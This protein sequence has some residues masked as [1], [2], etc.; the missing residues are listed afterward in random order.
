MAD[1]RCWILQK[2]NKTAIHYTLT[3]IHHPLRCKN[4]RSSHK[5]KINFFVDVV[6]CCWA[7]YV[8]L[9]TKTIQSPE[10]SG[11]TRTT[12]QRYSQKTRILSTSLLEP[13]VLP[14]FT[15]PYT[16][17]SDVTPSADVC[18]VC[19]IH[20]PVHMYEMIINRHFNIIFRGLIQLI[21]S[22]NWA[23]RHINNAAT[24]RKANCKCFINCIMEHHYCSLDYLLLPSVVTVALMR[25]CIIWGMI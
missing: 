24:L 21:C 20:T 1:D 8:A 9:K 22:T 3:V 15:H 14:C 6:L 25:S 23:G 12:T 4:A 19:G 18:Y 10:T 2:R 5:L 11:T 16:Q 7:D 17:N 13:Q